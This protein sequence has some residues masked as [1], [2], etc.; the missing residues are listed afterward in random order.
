MLPSITTV[1]YS[2]S[3]SFVRKYHKTD[4]IMEPSKDN[5]YV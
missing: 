4:T 2:H 3:I 5:C 1:N